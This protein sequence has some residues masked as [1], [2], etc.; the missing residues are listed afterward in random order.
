MFIQNIQCPSPGKVYYTLEKCNGK[1]MS[2]IEDYKTEFFE[3]LSRKYLQVSDK[4]S[5]WAIA[6]SGHGFGASDT[7]YESTI[8]KVP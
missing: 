5:I 8:E 2:E 6:C 1:Q 4:N 3:V 7:H